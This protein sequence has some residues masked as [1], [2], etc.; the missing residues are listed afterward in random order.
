M[1]FGKTKMEMQVGIFV[2]IGLAI[3]VTFVLLIGNIRTWTSG[4][5]VNFIFNFANGVKVGS[6][7]RYAGVDVGEVKSIS[8]LPATEGD[9]EKIQITGWLK[10][11]VRIPADSTVWIDTLGLLGEKY[12][13]VMPGNDHVNYV[14]AAGSLAGKDPIAMH[15]VMQMA[16][17]LV[18]NID[19]GIEK[20]KN[21]EGTVGKLLYDD[22]IYR[23][24]E[25]L[26]IDLRKHPWKLFH[27]TKEK[28]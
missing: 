10:K 20:I 12:I 9:R 4:Y 1:I 3:L 21:K 26:M 13:E 19:D 27:K 18:G 8:F 25:A 22:A 7:V 5:R 2:F 11:E 24:L 6:P 15:E 16:R 23:E 14:A 17:D 28:K